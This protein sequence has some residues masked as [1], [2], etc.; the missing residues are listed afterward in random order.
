MSAS[1]KAARDMVFCSPRT[2][3]RDHQNTCY[4]VYACHE[5]CMC[6]RINI[7][8]VRYKYRP[9]TVRVLSEYCQDTDRPEKVYDQIKRGIQGQFRPETHL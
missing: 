9:G 8:D 5:E 4:I 2:H 6:S 1:E 3:P 7:Y